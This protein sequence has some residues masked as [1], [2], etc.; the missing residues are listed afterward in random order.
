MDSVFVSSSSR[1]IDGL[2]HMMT[3]ADD[4]AELVQSYVDVS[5]ALLIIEV[6]KRADDLDEWFPHG[7]WATIQSI[8]GAAEKQLA[9]AFKRPNY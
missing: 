6:A 2:R 1:V 8:Q 7:K 4:A 5:T 3:A 9:T